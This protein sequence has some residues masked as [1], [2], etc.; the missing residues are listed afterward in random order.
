AMQIAPAVAATNTRTGRESPPS[1]PAVAP[2][3]LSACWSPLLVVARLPD[4]VCAAFASVFASVFAPV[5]LAFAPP[6][7][8]DEPFVEPPSFPAAPTAA[9]GAEA[10]GSPAGADDGGG[11]FDGPPSGGHPSP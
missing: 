8:G 10:G 4:D 1:A 6:G 11:A 3:A 5:A 2:F 7:L 9:G